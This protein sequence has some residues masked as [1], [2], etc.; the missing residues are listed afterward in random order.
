MRR[1]GRRVVGRMGFCPRGRSLGAAGV[2]GGLCRLGGGM[3]CG[4]GWD[5]RGGRGS[6][7]GSM[8]W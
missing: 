5:G 1:L 3:G 6:P 8:E 4:A 7:R 2:G